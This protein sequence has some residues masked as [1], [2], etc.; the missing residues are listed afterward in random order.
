[1][2]DRGDR[3]RT[4]LDQIEDGCS[5]VDL[6]G[7]VLFVN[8]AFCRMFG[9]V[10]DEIVGS[11]FRSFM[12]EGRADQL[13]QAYSQVYTTGVPV[14]AFEY[15]VFAKNAST[16]FVEQTISLDRDRDGQAVGFVAITRDCTARKEAEEAAAKAKEAAEAAN[17]A[18]SEFLAN[19]SHEIRTPMNGIIGM[20]IL[21]L[22]TG[23]TPYQR[24][25]LLTVKS[26]A[27]CLLTIINDILDFSKVESRK[28]ELESIPF[29]L[30]ES[31]N[32]AIR[33]LA[34][35][36]R[37]KGL[38]FASKIA[39]DVPQHVIGDPVRLRQIVINLIANAIKFTTHGSVT[40]GIGVESLDTNGV[41]LHFC[42]ADTG[43]GIPAAQ[44][45]RVFE[46][47]QQA[48]G[49]T[50]RQFGGSGLGLAI[51]STLVQLMNGRIW[52][53][54]EP[55]AGSTFHFNAVFA[56]P[57]TSS[58]ASGVV[59]GALAGET[60][61]R[62]QTVLL[63]EDNPVNVRVVQGLLAKRG[64][65]VTVVGNGRDA[66]DAAAQHPF[67]VVLMDVQMPDVDGFE[68][69]IAI[70]AREQGSGQRVRIIA[71]TAHAMSGDRDRC[72]AAG[73]DDYV[74]KPIDPR[75]L[76]GAVERTVDPVR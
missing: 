18:K 21:A 69:T 48:D 54:S 28:M 58:V 39:P 65:K 16:R 1:M 55:G 47:F 32:D 11:N 36:A 67:D 70:R 63:A 26:Q 60:P 2:T 20:T 51:A 45:Q 59:A 15:R 72:I 37:G 38:D 34:L 42:I 75:A 52:V 41:T 50:T 40:L 25:C 7:N 4:I 14:K 71:M 61:I 24:E 12:G 68:A 76:Y 19:M 62:P 33:P 3:Y 66:I 74:S 53:D 56:T 6:R 31:I 64:H 57:P 13:R 29:P 5:V 23:L 35:G 17:R 10:R 27:D 8:D 30:V 43:I 44:Q 46:P 73:M 9:F 22:D 49:S